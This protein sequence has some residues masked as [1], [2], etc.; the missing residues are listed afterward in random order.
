MQL[1]CTYTV[2]SCAY[3]QEKERFYKN[4]YNAPVFLSLYFYLSLPYLITL[5]PS[6]SNAL[7]FFTSFSFSLLFFITHIFRQTPRLPGGIRAEQFN[8]HMILVLFIKV[9]EE[10]R[11]IL[12]YLTIFWAVMQQFGQVLLSIWYFRHSTQAKICNLMKII[13]ST[14]VICDKINLIT[15]ISNIVC[16]L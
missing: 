9:K 12:R 8:R 2:L 5:I 11:T 3:T 10:G 7:P 16:P 15:V 13:S 4:K 14:M 1:T 6:F